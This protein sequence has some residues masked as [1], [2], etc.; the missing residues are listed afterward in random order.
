VA[1]Q[2]QVVVK[3]YKGSESDAN[4]MFQADAAKMAAKGYFPTAQSWAPGNYG[5]GAFIVAVLLCFILIG[6]LVFVYMLIVKPAGTLTVTYELRLAAPE[7]SA[8]EKTC[9][10]CA[11]QVKAAATVCRFCGYE[12]SAT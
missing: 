2:N 11:E 10:R 6:I 12:F 9:P 5:C 1:Q 3:T 8:A 4:I 7:A